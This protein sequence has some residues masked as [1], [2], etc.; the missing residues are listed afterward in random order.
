MARITDLRRELT[1]KEKKVAEIKREKMRSLADMKPIPR[2]IITVDTSHARGNLDALKMVLKELEWKEYPFGRK[3]QHCDI[4]WHCTNFEQNPDVYGGKVNKFPSMNWIC[5]KMNLFRVLD[6]MRALYPEDYDFYPRSWYLPEQLHQLANDI[7]KMTE[8]KPK[9]RPTFIVK[10]D[11]G[12]QGEG[13][14]LLRDVHDYIMNNGRINVCQEYLADVFLIDRF[15]FDLRVYTVLTSL[16]P[17]EFYICKEGLARFS[18]VPYENPTNKNLHE[19]FMHLTNYSLNKKSSTFNRSERDDEGSKRTL[20]SVFTRLRRSGHNVDKL[21]QRIERI[22]VKTLLAITPDLKIEFQ[23]ALPANKP[24]PSCFQILGFDIILMNNLKPMLLEINGS[25]SLRIDS[26]VEVSPGVMEYMPSP[27]DEEVKLPL[28]RDAMLLVAPKSKIKYLQRKRRQRLKRQ[29]ARRER[30]RKQYEEDKRLRKEKEDARSPLEMERDGMIHVETHHPRSSIVIIRASDDDH[31]GSKKSARESS[32][33]LPDIHNPFQRSEDENA[34][35]VIEN[36]NDKLEEPLR[37]LTMYNQRTDFVDTIEEEEQKTDGK[38][39]VESS[40]RQT[41]RNLEEEKEGYDYESDSDD[42]RMSQSDMPE[43]CLKKIYPEGYEEK[44]D[45]L[46]LYEKL[47]SIFLICLGVRSTQRLGP[48]GFRTFARKCRLS[49]KGLANASV[50]ILYIDMQ[51]KWEHTNPERTTGLG[52]RGFLDACHEI[53]KRKFQN[54]DTLQTME[55]FIDYCSDNLQG[56][57]TTAYPFKNVPKLLA[58]RANRHGYP[59]LA[60][61]GRNE[62]IDDQTRA[63]IIESHGYAKPRSAEDVDLFLQRRAR[64]TPGKDRGSGSR[65]KS[66]LKAEDEV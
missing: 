42:E 29:K 4:H 63:L 58:R 50:D 43:S 5:S 26:E 47:A 24:G 39:E 25:P 51:R 8:K 35:Q 9:P 46:R 62:I 40:D 66:R 11:T 1:F 6:Q 13:I 2:Y 18:T 32:F 22:V 27:K 19:T 33:L 7:R 21:W 49:K 30:R 12:S 44:Y 60:P 28:I 53:A 55:E 61:I 3:D 15:K 57:V 20:T 17:L 10:P 14:Y 41:D 38:M 54:G 48:S 65:T 59:M 52:F 36:L 37:E 56:E 34:R 45:R 64:V 23:S 16:E 31:L